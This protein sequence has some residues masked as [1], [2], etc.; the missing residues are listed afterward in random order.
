MQKRTKVAGGPVQA[1][2]GEAS[3]RKAMGRKG[4]RAQ[5]VASQGDAEQGAPV[6]VSFLVKPSQ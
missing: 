6:A 1:P 2:K 3:V 5:G 4:G